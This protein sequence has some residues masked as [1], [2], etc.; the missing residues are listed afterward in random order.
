MGVLQKTL[1]SFEEIFELEPKERLSK[2]FFTLDEMMIN[3]SRK[4]GVRGPKGI[5]SRPLLKALL[6]MKLYSIDSIVLLRD[7]L[8]HDLRLKYACGFNLS[9]S[10]PSEATFS[11]FIA[12]LASNDKLQK[13]FEAVVEK[14]RQLGIIGSDARALD[15]TDIQAYEM[16]RPRKEIQQDGT[17]ADWGLKKDC[18]GHIHNWFGYKLHL[19]VDTQSECPVRIELTPASVHDGDPAPGLIEEEFKTLPKEKTVY[20]IMDAG[21]DQRKIYDTV[22]QNRGRPIIPI[23]RRSEKQPPPGIDS[24]GTPI[25]SAGFPM[26]YWG[27]S[28][29]R[30]PHILGKVDCP[31]GSNWCSSSYY[32]LVVKINPKDDARRFC[33][34]HRGTRNWER[35]YDQRTTVERAF[36]RLKVNLGLENFKV[37]GIRKVFVHMLLS[38]ICLVAGTISVNQKGCCESAA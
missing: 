29:F 4:T 13:L 2:F 33:I 21:Y 20:F 11:R 37:R 34:P 24:N 19:M 5:S 35:L 3:P 38:S 17:Q 10:V 25:C 23:N 31:F 22:V 12:Y 7:R 8:E 30:C 28:K 9:D 18:N 16:K 6:V 27:D 1:F 26:V 15:S 36:S 32:G 14:G